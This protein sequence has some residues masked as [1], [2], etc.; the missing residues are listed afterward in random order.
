MSTADVI[1]EIV[2]HH[3]L[4]DVWRNHHPDDVLTFTYVW[5]QAHWSCYSRLDCIYLSHFHL[6][7]AHSSTIRPAPFSDHHLVIVTASLYA[8]RPGLA[9][10]HFNNNLL[11]DVGFVA[12]FREFWLA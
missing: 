10:W 11:E 1:R 5:V 9:Y 3:S 12:S 6:S 4:V 7:R 2:E 8:E